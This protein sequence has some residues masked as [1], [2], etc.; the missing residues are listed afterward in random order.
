MKVGSKEYISLLERTAPPPPRLPEEGLSQPLSACTDGS[1]TDGQVVQY[2][3]DRVDRGW[4]SPSQ[5]R[6]GGGLSVSVL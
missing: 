3:A 1:Y 5:R 6:R 2:T 4:E